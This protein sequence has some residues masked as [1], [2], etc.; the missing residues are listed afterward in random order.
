MTKKSKLLSCSLSVN[1]L[2]FN[3]TYRPYPKKWVLQPTDERT[4]FPLDTSLFVK[5]L[6]ETLL[7][8][9]SNASRH[10]ANNQRI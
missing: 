5:H 9:M 2:I 3:T 4:T 6:Y 1:L 7:D 10:V 8:V